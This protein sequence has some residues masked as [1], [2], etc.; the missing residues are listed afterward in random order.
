[1]RIGI[2][3]ESGGVWGAIAA[4]LG[5]GLSAHAVDV[6]LVPSDLDRITRRIVYEYSRRIHPLHGNESPLL[7]LRNSQV[8]RKRTRLG[9]VAFWIQMGSSFAPPRSTPFVT[10][11]DMTVLLA[12]RAG[13][14]PDLT[15][16]VRARWVARQAFAY[17]HSRR[18]YVASDWAAA[19]VIADYAVSP[20]KVSTVGLGRNYEPAITTKDWTVPTFLWVGYDWVRKNGCRVLRAFRKVRC[21]YPSAALHLVGD[22]PPVAAPGVVSHGRLSSSDIAEATLMRTLFATA[23]CFVMP[24]R[25]EPFGIVYVEA[26]AAGTPS[27]GTTAGGAPYA[28]GPGGI[29]VDP[30]NQVALEDAMLAL[31]APGTAERLGAMARTHSAQFT[32]PRIADQIL[33]TL[34]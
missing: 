25:I 14:Y 26:G 20:H 6:K 5:S 30:D 22:H 19:S 17:E 11:E 1:M 21:L 12:L 31:C 16:Q 28:I 18:C 8:G 13:E 32:W 24:S 33:G 3:Y 29:C 15:D 2:C 9:P 34:A 4:G 23:T 7:V 27:I 10:F